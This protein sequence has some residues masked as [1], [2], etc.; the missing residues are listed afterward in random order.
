M[1]GASKRAETC[2]F[3]CTIPKTKAVIREDGRYNDQGGRE[4]EQRV[5][6][7]SSVIPWCRAHA[8]AY[9]LTLK[10]VESIEIC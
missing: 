3:Y 1:F 8:R 10:Y 4:E 2:S 7:Y 9:L 6:K 5:N